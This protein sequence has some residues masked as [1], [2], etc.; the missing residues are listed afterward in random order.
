MDDGAR[1]LER[2]KAQLQAELKRFEADL[3]SKHAH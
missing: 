1:E 3:A 2:F